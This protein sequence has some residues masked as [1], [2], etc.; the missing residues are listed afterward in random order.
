[1][2]NEQTANGWDKH[3]QKYVANDVL[4]GTNICFCEKLVYDIILMKDQIQ[5]EERQAF[6]GCIKCY[7]KGYST[8]ATQE[9]GAPD[10][11]MGVKGYKKQI[12]EMRFCICDRGRQLE[13]RINQER[14]KAIDEKIEIYEMFVPEAYSKKQIEILQKQKEE[15]EK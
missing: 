12:D 5:K 15:L 14:L 9:I 3:I 6:G 7:G 2:T 11:E 1:M 4:D 8:R 13:K 10:H